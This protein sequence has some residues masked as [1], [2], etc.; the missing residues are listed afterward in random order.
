ML[1]ELVEQAINEYEPLIKSIIKRFYV[2]S[3]D[4]DDLYQ[5]GLYGLYKA[6][7]RYNDNMNVK[8]STYAFKYIYGEVYKEYNKLS[9]YGNISFN[10]IRRYINNN[11][12]L[13][14]SE[15]IKNLNISLDTYFS[16]ISSIDKV[17]FVD[18]EIIDE[19][20]VIEKVDSIELDES[21]NILYR[22]YFIH[23]LSQKQIAKLLSISQA[24]V[25]RKVQLLK[26]TILK[27]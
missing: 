16:V 21:S 7:D 6:I 13:T 4:Y 14:S 5:A 24:S 2:S 3:Y 11:L 10:K 18:E 1:Q 26:K 15:V 25:S 8:L 20:V 22:Y 23:K 27:K 19:K 9:L 12:D 17:S